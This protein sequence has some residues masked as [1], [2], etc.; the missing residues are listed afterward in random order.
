MINAQQQKI[1]PVIPPGAIIDNTSPTVTVIDTLDFEWA[2][3][4]VML[5]A[6]DIAMAALSLQQSDASGSGFAVITGADFAT[7]KNTDGST[8][9]LTSASDDNHFFAFQVDLR[10]KKR[11]LKLIATGGDGT[12]GAYISAFAL[13]S[14]GHEVPDSMSKRGFTQEIKV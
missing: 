13:L 14:R 5:G 4:V 2:T 10:G 6:T 11:Y 12:A 9:T 1:V 8:A 7:G 3:I